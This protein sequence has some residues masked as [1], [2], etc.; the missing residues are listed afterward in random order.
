[1]NNPFTP[2]FG[3]IPY[4][5]AGRRELIHELNHAYE[6]A[7]GDPALTSILIGARGTGKTA[8]LS[9]MQRD[10]E[11]RD[12]IAVGV[13]CVNGMMED[14]YE[15]T[16]R[17]SRHL[18]GGTGKG[19]SR[20]SVKGSIGILSGEIGFDKSDSGVTPNWRSRMTDLL[21]ELNGQGKGLLITIDEVNPSLQE[22]IDFTA[23]YQLFLREE[24]KIG[25]LMAGLPSQISSLL[26]D[27][28]VSFL[29]RS[30][31]YSLASI[32]DD[33]IGE[34]FEK[35][36]EDGGKTI[37][38]DAL[39]EA[40]Q[41]ING[42]PFMLQ[43]IG[44]WTWLNADKEDNI[45]REHVSKGI[46][47]AKI[48]LEQS[49]LRPTINEVSPMGIRFLEAMCEDEDVSLTKDIASRLGKTASY[50]S[51]YKKRLM[52]LGIIEEA[53]RG[54]LRF[55]LPYMKEYVMEKSEDK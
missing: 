17:E 8:L 6:N 32:P 31:Q 20:V 16:I 13:A 40:V 35:T 51:T 26:K 25:L 46:S 48:K 39:E 30:S 19:V 18:I 38:F 9:Y 12:W 2:N 10:V 7:P 42:F 29:R 36:V 23:Q 14:I 53:G 34:A 55:S 21:E 47:R 24:R 43:L 54:K 4:Q 41:A 50:I 1:M 5:L 33:D 22:M 28:S 37:S 3:Q 27:K 44:Y 45:S 49:V 15:Q 52:E 11:Q